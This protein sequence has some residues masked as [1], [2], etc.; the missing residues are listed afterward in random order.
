V[1]VLDN[2]RW[3]AYAHQRASGVPSVQAATNVGFKHAGVECARLNRHPK[4]KARIAE[5]QPQ[6]GKL[7]AEAIA[8]MV[9]PTRE[10]VLRDLIEIREAA[11]Q[12]GRLPER[13]KCNELIGKELGM[14]AVRVDAKVESA[15][16]K[17]TVPAVLALLA[18]LDRD[19][20]EFRPA[21]VIEHAPEPEPDA[22]PDADIDPLS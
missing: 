15:A 22:G 21:E 4:I 18:A 3:E 1:P 2:H 7:Q 9:V 6:Y 8:K 5:L 19:D 16:D 12:A 11:K 20:V 17:L 14:F 10:G 13:I